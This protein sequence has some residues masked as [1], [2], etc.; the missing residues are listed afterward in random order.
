[1]IVQLV[2]DGV[3]GAPIIAGLFKDDLN[4][5]KIPNKIFFLTKKRGFYNRLILLLNLYR[6]ISRLKKKHK[7]ICHF[8]IESIMLSILFRNRLT[9]V[10]HGLVIGSNKISKLFWKILFKSIIPR[11]NFIFVNDKQAN[12]CGVEKVYQNYPNLEMLNDM[13]RA[14]AS[15]DQEKIICGLVG[16]FSGQKNNKFILNLLLKYHKEIEIRYL[17]PDKKALEF[18]SYNNIIKSSIHENHDTISFFS[19]I[20]VLFVPSRWESFSLISYEFWYYG[21]LVVH[22]GVDGLE[23]FM[24]GLNIN[25]LDQNEWDTALRNLIQKRKFDVATFDLNI[26][27]RQIQNRAL[28]EGLF[29][30]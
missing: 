3:G 22:S 6:I 26:K 30:C 5:L 16:S 15:W 2:H 14:K 28:L 20:N 9:Y 1:M 27:N 24:G 7:I 18:L 12:Y 21:G 29:K 23:N 4:S 11:K 13:G 19:K 17:N 8:G 25:G 10:S